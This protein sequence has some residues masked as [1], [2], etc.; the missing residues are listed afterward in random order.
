VPCLPMRLTMVLPHCEQ[1]G[2]AAGV[3][4]SM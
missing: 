2:S 4:E 1:A 3:G